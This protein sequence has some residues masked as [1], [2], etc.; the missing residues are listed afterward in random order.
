VSNELWNLKSKN[1]KRLILLSNSGRWPATPTHPCSAL[2]QRGISFQSFEWRHN[3]TLT[4]CI[5]GPPKLISENRLCGLDSIKRSS[6]RESLEHICYKQTAMNSAINSQSTPNLQSSA[7]QCNHSHV[8]FSAPQFPGT[9]CMQQSFL[10]QPWY[11][12]SLY[13]HPIVEYRFQ[14]QLSFEANIVLVSFIRNVWFN[15][16]RLTRYQVKN[17][18]VSENIL[19]IC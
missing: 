9:A 8:N 5:L 12:V 2:T 1:L 11:D 15:S 6:E 18:N 7:I 14:P 16:V 19:P 17:R 3:C 13:I 4:K 10:C